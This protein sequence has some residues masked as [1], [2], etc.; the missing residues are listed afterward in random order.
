MMGGMNNE[1]LCFEFLYRMSLMI[2]PSEKLKM[3]EGQL[4]INGQ[5][6]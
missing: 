1:S 3:K 2:Q 4:M 6:P 5:N